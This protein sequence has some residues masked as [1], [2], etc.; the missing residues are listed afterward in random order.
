MDILH[1]QLHQTESTRVLDPAPGET[2]IHGVPHDDV[3]VLTMSGIV[4]RMNDKYGPLSR[5]LTHIKVAHVWNE[6][7]IP[8]GSV[9]VSECPQGNYNVET[10]QGED[11]TCSTHDDS[12]TIRVCG[13]DLPPKPSTV[14]QLRRPPIRQTTLQE[15]ITKIEVTYTS[16][17]Q[18][19]KTF[20][21]PFMKMTLTT[22][23][24]KYVRIVKENVDSYRIQRG[25]MRIATVKESRLAVLLATIAL[26]D[27]DVISLNGGLK[28]LQRM[29]QSEEN[30]KKWIQSVD[31]ESITKRI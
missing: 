29:L 19:L 23:A 4:E 3:D 27:Q 17:P 6:E 15:G 30:V 7:S 10:S 31:L 22:S 18:S 28:W 21:A 24:R 25:G 26:M 5:M 9:L 20:V 12:V 1:G 8:Q 2:D 16:L 13:N 14:L 11:E